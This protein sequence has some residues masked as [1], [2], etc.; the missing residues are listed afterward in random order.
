MKPIRPIHLHDTG[1][2]VSNL[3]KGLLFLVLH[4]PAISD[5]DRKT[6]QSRLA[7]E[8]R[9]QI[10]GAATTELVGIWQNQLKNWPDYFP[11]LP[12]ELKAK[13]RTLGASPTGRG[14]GDVDEVTAEAFNWLLRT[15]GAL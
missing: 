8:V 11:P 2:E 15:F 1:A 6:L 4:Q 9:A 13:V 3:H 12:Q 5:S 14:T 7:P 10:Y